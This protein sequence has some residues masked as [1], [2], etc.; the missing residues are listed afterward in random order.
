[1]DDDEVFELGDE[2]RLI[3]VAADDEGHLEYQLHRARGCY[4]RPFEPLILSEHA[5]RELR[6][7]MQEIDVALLDRGHAGSFLA[8]DTRVD[9]WYSKSGQRFVTFE[10][11]KETG[12]VTKLTLPHDAWTTLVAKKKQIDEKGDRIRKYK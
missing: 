6:R 7:L 3:I 4:P 11:M 8:C 9:T 2:H 5:W 12:A 1:M 10:V